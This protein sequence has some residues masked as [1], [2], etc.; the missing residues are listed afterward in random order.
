[1]ADDSAARSSITERDALMQLGRYLLVARQDP[2]PSVEI[3]KQIVRT[4]VGETVVR[5]A[6][7]H[8]LGIQSDRSADLVSRL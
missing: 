5:A 2:I 1:M 6:A 4:L 7:D 3:K 8:R